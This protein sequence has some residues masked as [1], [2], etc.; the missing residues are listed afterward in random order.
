MA[1]V[2][3]DLVPAF[4]EKCIRR[5]LTAGTKTAVDL[6]R[7]A[8]A[9]S[10][11]SATAVLA[12]ERLLEERPNSSGALGLAG[13]IALAYQRDR[14]DDSLRVLVEQARVA[15]GM[16]ATF[17]E[18]ESVDVTSKVLL[19][20]ISKEVAAQGDPG[21]VVELLDIENARAGARISRSM[22]GGA[23]LLAFPDYDDDPRE[24]V[25][26]PEVRLF[27]GHLHLRM[28]YFPLFMRAEPKFGAFLLYFGCLAPGALVPDRRAFSLDLASPELMSALVTSMRAIAALRR[29]LPGL[30]IDE[31]VNRLLTPYPPE[32]AA[33]LRLVA[34][35]EQ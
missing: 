30:M 19:I 24:L 8:N 11:D 31:G 29:W 27:I 23:V 9:V 12:V 5:D 16:S 7:V 33:H 25:V 10:E 4:I 17:V 15:A 1:N 21:I 26:I 20:P 32:A 34:A 3:E 28:P 22:L 2:D 14:R 35:D 6:E 13:A 18:L